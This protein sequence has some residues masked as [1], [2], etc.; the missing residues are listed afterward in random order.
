MSD[1]IILSNFSFWFRSICL[2]KTRGNS[3]IYTKK[4]GTF[5]D[6]SGSV[7]VENEL[8]EYEKSFQVLHIDW[9]EYLYHPEQL[10]F[11]VQVDLFDK[12][13]GNSVMYT[14]KWSTFSYVWSSVIVQNEIR[15]AEK[16]CKVIHI[17]W[18]DWFYHPE[19]LFM[20]VQIDLFDKN[21]GK[22]RLCTLRNEVLFPMSEAL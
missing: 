20:P 3:A 17:G 21:M 5:S 13:R 11:L 8:G 15:E 9:Y 18:Y 12:T 6:S 14:K 16:S 2:T 10:F 19:Q 22:T 1:F 7:L 4:W